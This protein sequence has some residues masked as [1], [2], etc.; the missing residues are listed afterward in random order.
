M[1]S[2]TLYEI[3]KIV[4]SF[5][6][7]MQ[8]DVKKSVIGAWIGSHH[9]FYDNCFVTDV[10]N[11]RTSFREALEPLIRAHHEKY[12]LKSSEGY[13]PD[14]FREIVEIAENKFAGILCIEK[15]IK[16]DTMSVTRKSF[17]LTSCIVLSIL[18]AI[19]IGAQWPIKFTI[20]LGIG[21]I[22]VLIA[23]IY[24]YNASQRTKII[25]VIYE[26]VCYLDRMFSSLKK[27]SDE[28]A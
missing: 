12:Y 10:I 25:D 16:L 15:L 2:K 14:R 17:L 27:N 23:A 21:I 4:E 24:D 11:N 8:E 7:Y 28:E 3:L 9:H 22:I 13:S 26:R 5:P 20:S 1:A 19:S 6:N 18:F